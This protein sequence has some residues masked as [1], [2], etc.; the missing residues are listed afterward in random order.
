MVYGS[1]FWA[2]GGEWRWMSHYFGW[3]GVGGK[4]SCMGVGEWS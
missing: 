1:L 2:D 4:I 3:V